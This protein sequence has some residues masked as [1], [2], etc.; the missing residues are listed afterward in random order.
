VAAAAADARRGQLGWDCG[1]LGL[2]PG[3]P[4]EVE[5][6]RLVL[7]AGLE[8]GA[9]RGRLVAPAAARF[10]GEASV[11]RSQGRGSLFKPTCAPPRD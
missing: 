8:T 7:V 6:R 2:A 11:R 3:E 4:R 5:E 10:R 9:R 1:R